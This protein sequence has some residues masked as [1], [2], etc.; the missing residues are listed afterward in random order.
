M[1]LQQEA[2]MVSAFCYRELAALNEA[3]E[4]RKPQER[5]R[6]LQH[7][8]GVTSLK[9]VTATQ[10]YQAAFR[11]A[12]LASKSPEAM[13]AWLRLGERRAQQT[14]TAP[15]DDRKLRAALNE[16]RGLTSKR[17]E[18]FENELR[19]RLAAC[20]VALVICP[21]FPK[22][23]AHGATFRLGQRTVLMITVRG[24]W[25]DIFWFTLFHEVGHILLHGNTLMIEGCVANEQEAEA[26]SFARDILIPAKEYRTFVCQR[27]FSHSSV[28][29]F[30]RSAGV[31]PGIVVGR[32]H[33]DG[34]I[35]PSWLNDLR[36]RLS[37]KSGN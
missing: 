35:Q 15:F 23:G 12:S 36:V 33:H 31:H 28:S 29:S 21:H 11:C 9:L 8:F 3:P 2:E 5:V 18:Q 1:D 25:A 20:G 10:R 22:T 32:L 7:F 26:D 24:A 19:D 6:A 37:L 14:E 16:L 27:L 13:A 4:T 34:H 30:A 17:P